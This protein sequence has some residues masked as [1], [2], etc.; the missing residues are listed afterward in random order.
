MDE[1]EMQEIR[2]VD[3]GEESDE[4]RIGSELAKGLSLFCTR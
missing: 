1:R 4:I 2:D 3:V